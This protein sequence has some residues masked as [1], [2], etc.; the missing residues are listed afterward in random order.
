MSEI[1]RL[2]KIGCFYVM[3]L[4][5]IEVTFAE[6]NPKFSGLQY[7]S[8]DANVIYYYTEFMH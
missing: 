1:R 4:D 6:A 8:I 2:D 7:S 5:K 3:N